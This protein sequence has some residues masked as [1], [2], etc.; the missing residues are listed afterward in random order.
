MNRNGNPDATFDSQWCT[1]PNM[2]TSPP[3]QLSSIHLGAGKMQCETAARFVYL[4]LEAFIVINS[5]IYLN[6]IYSLIRTSVKE[7]NTATTGSESEWVG[8]TL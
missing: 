5:N 1:T 3:A 2:I 6:G 8:E 7:T 4:L